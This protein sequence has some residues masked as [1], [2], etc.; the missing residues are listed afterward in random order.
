MPIHRE[1]IG[2]NGNVHMCEGSDP[3][4]CHYR[5]GVAPW[6]CVQLFGIAKSEEC[7]TDLPKNNKQITQKVSHIL[8]MFKIVCIMLR[9]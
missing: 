7:T 1:Y 9:S 8:S 4:L 6:W 2:A 5:E 3:S